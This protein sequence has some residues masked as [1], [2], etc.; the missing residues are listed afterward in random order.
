VTSYVQTAQA[1]LDRAFARSD[2]PDLALTLHALVYAQLA[3]AEAV[4]ES[5]EG[6][7]EQISDVSF[8][9]HEL[10]LVIQD[11]VEQAR[12][13]YALLEEVRK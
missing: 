3:N 6:L 5:V 4:T 7:H 10:V 13:L 2:K 1:L 11:L 8:G 12:P 9:I